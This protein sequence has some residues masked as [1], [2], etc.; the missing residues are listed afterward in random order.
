MTPRMRAMGA[1]VGLGAGLG[2]VFWLL[3]DNVA[4][5]PLWV[6]VGVVMGAAR[7]NQASDDHPTSGDDRR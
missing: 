4:L 1:G 3:F 7:A 2:L 6:G 5:F